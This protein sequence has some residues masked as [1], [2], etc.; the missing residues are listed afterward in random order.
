MQLPACKAFFAMVM[1]CALLFTAGLV[2]GDL[3]KI[4]T[5]IGSLDNWSVERGTWEAI[6]DGFRGTGNSTV[7]FKEALPADVRISFTVNVAKGMRPRMYFDGPN[8]MLGNEGYKKTLAI[9]GNDATDLKGEEVAYKNGEPLQVSVVITGEKFAVQINDQTLTGTCLKHDSIRLRFRGGDPWSPGSTEYTNFTVD[10]HLE[11]PPPSHPEDA[12]G[13]GSDNDSAPDVAPSTPP[14]AV[15]LNNKGE[16]GPTTRISKVQTSIEALYVI[17]EKSG[18]DAGACVAVYPDRD[19]RGK[20]RRFCADHL[21]NARGPANA[22]GSG[23]RGAG[24]QRAVWAGG[25]IEHGAEL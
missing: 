20:Q 10:D 4:S 13:P 1:V 3:Q 6:P 18:V 21:R 12:P 5:D 24:D 9:H 11:L 19:S 17:E 2:R 25:R 22:H 7:Q 16:S 14:E 15:Q 23:R 8:F